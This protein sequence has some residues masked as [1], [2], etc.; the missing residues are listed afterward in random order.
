MSLDLQENEMSAYLIFVLS[1]TRS[2]TPDFV[3]LRAF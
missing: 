1:S 3:L 2:L